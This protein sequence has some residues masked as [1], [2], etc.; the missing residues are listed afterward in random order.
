MVLLVS[1]AVMLAAGAAAPLLDRWLGRSAGYPLAAVFAG[2]LVWLVA[3]ADLVLAGGELVE[4]YPWVPALD[5]ALTLRLDGL[6]L[7]FVG[8]VLFV[9]AL[10][11]SYTPRYLTPGSHGRL[12]TVLTVFA[13]AM[14]GLVLSGDIILLLVFWEITTLCSFLLIAGQGTVGAWP[15]TRALLVTAGGG[16]ALLAAAVMLV[17]ATGTSDLASI[18][19][20]APDVLTPTQKLVVAALII[21][22]AFTKSAQVPLHFWLP[23]AM[24]AITPV[25]AY[26]HAATLVKAGIYLLLRT[27]PMFADQPAWHLVLMSVG[28]TTAV[29]G[30]VQALRQHDLK[31]LLAYSTVS[32]LGFIV[33]LVGIGTTASLAA[34]ALLTLAHALFKATLFMLVG[35]ID[36]EAGSRDVRELSGLRRVMPVTAVLTGLAALSMA[37]VPPLVG[38]VAKEESFYAFVGVSGAT[39]AGD[40]AALSV[41][42]GAVAV[43]AAALTLAYSMRILVGAFAGPVRQPDLYE[44]AA[45]FLLPAAVPAVLGLVLGLAPQVL[46][47]LVDRAVV[48]T[49]VDAASADLAL[50]HGFTIALWMSVAALSLGLA[51]HRWGVRRVPLLDQPTRPIAPRVFDRGWSGALALG[52][53]VGVPRGSRPAPHLALV[54]AGVAAVLG[55]GLV[56]LPSLAPT[57]EGTSR[58]AD[59]AVL[60]VLLPALA[61]LAVARRSLTALVMV[62]A[63]GFALTAW[64]LLLGAP[65]VALTLLL[66][67]LLTVVVAVPVVRGRPDAL[68]A[69]TGRVTTAV[70][71][72]VAVGLGLVAAAAVWMLTGR[73][74]R[75]SVGDYL[76]AE[77]ETLTGGA[78]V[79]NTVLVDFRGLDTLGEIGVLVAAAVGLQVLLGAMPPATAAWF[80]GPESDVLATGARAVVPALLAT[81]G[82]L[83][84]R[85]HDLPGGGFIAGLVLGLAVVVARRARWRLPLPSSRVLLAVGLGTTTA[86]ALLGLAVAGA[87]GAPLK[88]SLALLGDPTT[89]LAFDL[90]VVLVVLGLV[91]A[92]VDRLEAADEARTPDSR[93]PEPRE[94]VS[95]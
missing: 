46:N 70:S 50:W 89:A 37:G 16:L 93:A 15:A 33:A 3:H 83:F 17:V 20:T 66:V 67:E 12:F 23:D 75:S 42:S 88:A 80:R 9:G 11:M 25:S 47:P 38:F 65:D 39:W 68:P 43:G 69:S 63:V 91:S 29:F 24:V 49:G 14:L 51:I 2:V 71:A 22:A 78:N 53:R 79:V 82:I 74:S 27:S 95:A 73:A 59:V 13:A 32:Q 28:L 19:G 61:A 60:V 76:L 90:G 94:Q 55:I 34:A 31:A 54:A 56:R 72:V 87:F 85:G 86:T 45:A 48:D 10:V 6:S 35:I 26:L 8:L 21:V 7:L 92:A 30:A 64:L 84:W 57:L 62:G 44:P 40:V 81:A 18:I 5:V 36:R 52:A 58:G 41:V 1:V 77:A 4:T